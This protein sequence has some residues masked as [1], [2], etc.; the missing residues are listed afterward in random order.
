MPVY[1]KFFGW[2]PVL[3]RYQAELSQPWLSCRNIHPGFWRQNSH[4]FVNKILKFHL[5]D[6]TNKLYYFFSLVIS[7]CLTFIFI[8]QIKNFSFEPILEEVTLPKILFY[9]WNPFYNF[10]RSRYVPRLFE[11]LQGQKTDNDTDLSP[12]PLS[13]SIKMTPLSWNM[14]P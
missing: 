8:K 10:L 4:Y 12:T 1:G 13:L 6:H 3:H 11:C 5:N 2:W 9:L 7:C 14:S